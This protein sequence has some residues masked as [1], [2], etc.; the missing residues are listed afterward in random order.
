M[1]P[2][3]DL[4]PQGEVHPLD[5][6]RLS[7]GDR[8]DGA[9]GRCPFNRLAWFDLMARHCYPDSAIEI[10]QANEGGAVVVLPLVRQDT[11]RLA[12]LSN[13]FSFSFS[14]LIAGADRDTALHLL[15]R[16]ASDLRGKAGCISLHPVFDDEGTAS[17]LSTAFRAA[18]WHV[19]GRAGPNNHILDLDGR[20]FATY[21]AARP[22][23]LRTT[24]SRKCKAGISFDVHTHVDDALWADYMAIYDASWKNAETRAAFVRAMANEAAARGALRLAFARQD[25]R[26]LAAQIWTIDQV[27]ERRIGHIHKVAHDAAFDRLSPGTLLAHHM[28]ARA[29]DEEQVDRID[30]GTGDNAYKHDWMERTRPM[31]WLEIRDPRDPRQWLSIVKRTISGVA[32][33][34][35]PR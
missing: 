26:P 2:N 23:R 17:L 9:D 11:D 14:P 10:A 13:Y 12:S 32:G 1:V 5:P 4:R 27:G 18:G 16:I 34:L 6:V 31:L 7:H 15:T 28:F 29:I 30:Y 33:T 21:W 3:S 24:V 25:G 22:G 19:S 8:F 20:D 35:F